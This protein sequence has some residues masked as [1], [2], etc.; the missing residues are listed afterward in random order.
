MTGRDP[1]ETLALEV[2][3]SSLTGTAGE[4]WQVPDATPT[5][6]APQGKVEVNY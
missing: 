6:S 4:V 1:L 2:G 5:V 3:G